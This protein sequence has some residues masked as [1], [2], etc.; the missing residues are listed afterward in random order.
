MKR[1]YRLKCNFYRRYRSEIWGEI[2]MAGKITKIFKFLMNYFEFRFKKMA[3]R[4]LY[5]EQK[6]IFFFKKNLF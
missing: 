1:P 4:I 5:V 6:K 2:I 3:R